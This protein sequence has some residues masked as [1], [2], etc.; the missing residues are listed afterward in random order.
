MLFRSM[1]RMNHSCKPN[2]RLLGEGRPGRLLA[3]R[4]IKAKAR[5]F[6]D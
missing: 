4:G 5:S 1:S 2:V 3:L 6:L